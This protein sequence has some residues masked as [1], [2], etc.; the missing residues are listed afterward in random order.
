MSILVSSSFAERHK[1]GFHV[2]FDVHE[3]YNAPKDP[4]P[5]HG[6][7]VRC[8]IESFAGCCIKTETFMSQTYVITWDKTTQESRKICVTTLKFTIKY[9]I[10]ADMATIVDYEKWHL[11]HA[12]R[13]WRAKRSW[14]ARCLLDNRKKQKN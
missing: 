8:Y 3:H 1:P 10:D 5:L 12:E 11:S 9:T 13:R 6:P 4:N 14:R 7:F 2:L